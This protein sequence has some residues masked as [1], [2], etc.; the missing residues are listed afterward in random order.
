MCSPANS[1]VF[2][3]HLIVILT[4]LCSISA[5]CATTQ[6]SSPI[7]AALPHSGGAR[8]NIPPAPE[9]PV[10]LTSDSVPV[11]SDLHPRLGSRLSFNMKFDADSGG[12]E[13]STHGHPE[14]AQRPMIIGIR[15]QAGVIH[16]LPTFGKGD[17]VATARV[18]RQHMEM[19]SSTYDTDAGFSVTVTAPF[20]RS[21]TLDPDAFEVRAQIVP[22]FLVTIAFSNRTSS[23]GKGSFVLGLDRPAEEIRHGIWVGIG[24]HDVD[25]RHQ[26][27]WQEAGSAAASQ[28]SASTEVP[29]HWSTN[30]AFDP[31]A[32]MSRALAISARADSGAVCESGRVLIPY[33]VPP[34]ANASATFIVSGHTNRPYYSDMRSNAP[35]YLYYTRI[36]PSHQALLDWVWDNQLALQSTALAFDASLHMDQVKP[37][38][39]FVAILG[40]RGYLEN[41]TLSWDGDAGAY[42]SEFEA[43]FSGGYVNTM[44]LVPDTM[45]WDLNCHPWTLENVLRQFRGYTYRDK[46]GMSV[47]HDMGGHNFEPSEKYVRDHGPYMVT[48]EAANYLHAAYALW[49]FRDRDARWLSES[50]Q[51]VIDLTLSLLARDSNSDGIQD[52]TTDLG[53]EGNTID[54]GTQ[55]GHPR[56]NHYMAI[57]QWVAYRC[58]AEMLKAAGDDELSAKASLA[59]TTIAGALHR[60]IVEQGRFWSDFDPSSTNHGA[61]NIHLVKG[62]FTAYLVGLDLSADGQLLADC[63]THLENTWQ[64]NAFFYGYPITPGAAVQDLEQPERDGRCA[65]GEVSARPAAGCGG[66]NRQRVVLQPHLQ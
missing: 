41:S 24:Y 11:F 18:T 30:D 66:S 8:S 12:V 7:G 31:A 60:H 25:P 48:E 46:Y 38:E 49:R 6:E 44:D 3:A 53:R 9:Q 27:A 42:F 13:I 2:V 15:D 28:P 14:C 39:K 5:R 34:G 58:G 10:V 23:T 52:L 32:P 50:R 57:K 64:A 4:L 63:R 43:G 1:I 40:C 16:S 33:D 45:V 65:V 22:T 17:G 36:W 47:M 20:A 61:P 26:R 56:N 19:T 55:T 35:L 21:M 62:L 51:M 29:F 37:A 59:A 54:D